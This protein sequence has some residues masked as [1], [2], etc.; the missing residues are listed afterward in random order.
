MAQFFRNY[1]RLDKSQKQT[2]EIVVAGIFAGWMF[3]KD[4]AELM[5]Q[6]HHDIPINIII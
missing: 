4:C 3:Y 6:T 1:S 2:V 5:T